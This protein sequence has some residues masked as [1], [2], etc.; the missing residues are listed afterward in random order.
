MND[1]DRRTDAHAC[2]KLGLRAVVITPLFAEDKLLGVTAIFSR[3]PYAFGARE[4][5]TLQSTASKLELDIQIVVR[6]PYCFD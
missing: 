4:L 1:M 3:Q 6:Y 2:H 5:Q